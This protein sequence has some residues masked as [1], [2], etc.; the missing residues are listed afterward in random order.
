VGLAS[1]EKVSAHAPSDSTQLPRPHLLIL[2]ALN[3]DQAVVML[4]VDFGLSGADS[5]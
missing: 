4:P 5:L 1:L 3:L 2:Q